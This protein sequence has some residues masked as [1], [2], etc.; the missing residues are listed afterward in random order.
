MECPECGWCRKKSARVAKDAFSQTTVD[1]FRIIKFYDDCTVKCKLMI[2]IPGPPGLPEVPGPPGP[3][4]PPGTPGLS[5]T[6]ECIDQ[7]CLIDLKCVCC[8][9][10]F[11][12]IKCEKCWKH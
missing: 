3:P 12:P 8:L 7:T 10:Y 2:K 9:E 11:K 6:L 4:E 1:V 5:P